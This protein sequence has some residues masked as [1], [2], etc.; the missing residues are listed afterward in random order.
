MLGRTMRIIA[1]AAIAAIGVASP[2]AS[3]AAETTAPDPFKAKVVDNAARA[4]RTATSLG[5]IAKK[6]AP[7]GLSA[8]EKKSYDEQSRWLSDASSRFAVMKKTMDAVLAKAKVSPSELAQTS[9]QFVALVD[10]T[11]AESLRFDSLSHACHERHEAA[12]ASVK[13]P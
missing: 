1:L 6:P 2:L 3:H 9:M 5:S 10:A 8:D 11:Q 13:S 4:A 12:M 7:R